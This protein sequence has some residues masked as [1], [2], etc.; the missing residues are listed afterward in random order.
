MQFS[1]VDARTHYNQN[2]EVYA[3]EKPEG[4]YKISNSP[5]D[6]VERV[7]SPLHGTC[8]NL[9]MDNWFMSIPLAKKMLGH[10]VTVV[11][12]VRKNKNEI[13][14]EFLQFKNREVYH[15]LLGFNEDM[16]LL[17]YIPTKKNV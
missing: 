8:R 7:S 2:L 12:T 4:P 14:P 15:S 16:T 10:K 5:N 11:G 17:S 1:L 6:V 13:P 3:G 9:T